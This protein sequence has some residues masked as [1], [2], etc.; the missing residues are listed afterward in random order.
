KRKVG[1][2]E[3]QAM[4]I[5]QTLNSAQQTAADQQKTNMKML[6]ENIAKKDYDKTNEEIVTA[7]KVE[8]VVSKLNEFM[9]PLRTNLKFELH[10]EL[11][12]Y[13]VKVINLKTDE[14]I[15]EIPPKKMLDMY[16]AMAEFMGLLV[17]EKI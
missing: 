15:R 6:Q 13:Y 4:R 9:E 16:A 17:D 12:E 3:L 11:D 14:V 5:E 1:N 7:D 10:E 8:T 2:E